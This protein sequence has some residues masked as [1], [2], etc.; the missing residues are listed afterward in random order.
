M[1]EEQLVAKYISGLTY[2]IQERVI[3]RNMFSL[4]ESHKL[5]LKTER[6]GSK[7]A[8]FIQ[9]RWSAYLLLKKSTLM[10]QSL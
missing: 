6:W 7:V 1:T 3:L 9:S 5:T 2:S 10:L 8:T 4:D